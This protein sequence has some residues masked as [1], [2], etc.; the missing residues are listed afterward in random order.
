MDDA[1]LLGPAG[2]ALAAELEA[3]DDGADA[4]ATCSSCPTASPTW[5]ATRWACSHAPPATAVDDVLAAWA[6][7]GVDAHEDGAFPWMPYHETMRE[8]V[9][10]LVGARPGRGGRDEQPHRQ[11]PPDAG[12]L[13]PA[14]AE[15]S[16]IVIEADVFPSDRYA[17]MGGPRPARPD[18]AVEILRRR[19]VAATPT[20]T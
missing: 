1:E 7:L 16:R 20:R 15:R 18:E 12:Q 5:P 17:V 19:P 3:A 10:A 14:D 4:G 13:L 8:T 6:T 9:A 11:P 2:A